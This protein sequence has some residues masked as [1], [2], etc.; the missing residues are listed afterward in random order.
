MRRAAG[1]ILFHREAGETR[2]LLLRNAHHGTWSFPKGHLEPGEDLATGA[3]REVREETAIEAWR[4]VPGFEARLAYTVKKEDRPG[5]TED[6]RKE[7]VLF[8]GETPDRSW[9]R[10][11]E[12]DAGDWYTAS[13]VLERLGPPDLKDAF[14]RCVAFLETLP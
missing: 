4:H 9:Q 13:G 10:S 12:H 14:S 1:Y 8:L 6:Y 3:R 11:S 7:V 2:F 5:A